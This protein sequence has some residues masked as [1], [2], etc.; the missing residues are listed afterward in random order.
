MGEDISSIWLLFYFKVIRTSGCFQG[1][2]LSWPVAGSVPDLAAVQAAR[3]SLGWIVLVG[4]NISNVLGKKKKKKAFLLMSAVTQVLL[5]SAEFHSQ[6][7]LLWCL[8]EN[9]EWEL[10]MLCLRQHCSAVWIFFFLYTITIR[11][12]LLSLNVALRG[13]ES[14]AFCR[15]PFL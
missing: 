13:C 1:Q 2:M 11:F 4:N 7:Y 3:I 15:A 14:P 8:S 5:I 10:K 9:A 12:Y 6:T